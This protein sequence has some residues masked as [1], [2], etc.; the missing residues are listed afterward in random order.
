MPQAINPNAIHLPYDLGPRVKNSDK[1]GKQEMAKKLSKMDERMKHILVPENENPLRNLEEQ[2]VQRD[3]HWDGGLLP[4]GALGNDEHDENKSQRSA[5]SGSNQS[6]C[7][8]NSR[9]HMY[10][11]SQINFVKK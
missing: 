11:V 9:A 4:P 5:G 6:S 1:S 10:K 7:S 3:G 8:N 2:K